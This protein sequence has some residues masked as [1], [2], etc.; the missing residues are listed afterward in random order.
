MS[1]R[2]SD[3]GREKGSIYHLH[4][5]EEIDPRDGFMQRSDKLLMVRIEDKTVYFIAVV[6]HNLKNVW[7]LK[8]YIEIIKANWPETIERYRMNE[9]HL[10]EK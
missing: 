10:L 4:L 6:D 2:F 5:S 8:R 3:G 9:M 1:V 7:S